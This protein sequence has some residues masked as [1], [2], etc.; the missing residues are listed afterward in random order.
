MAAA[1]IFLSAT[2]PLPPLPVKRPLRQGAAPSRR[3]GVRRLRR[4]RRPGPANE[5]MRAAATPWR[6]RHTLRAAATHCEAPPLSREQAPPLSARLC[7]RLERRFP[8]SRRAANRR[9]HSPH[10][11]APGWSAAFFQ[12]RS[13]KAEARSADPPPRPREACRVRNEF[14]RICLLP[15]SRRGAVQALPRRGAKPRRGTLNLCARCVYATDYTL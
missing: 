4:A 11:C 9:R 1:G 2:L 8:T 5:D 6:R 7:S 10:A 3:G 13:A 14:S 15:S 12:A